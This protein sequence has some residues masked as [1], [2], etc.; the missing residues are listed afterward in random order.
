M[1]VVAFSSETVAFAE[2]FMFLLQLSNIA[3]AGQRGRHNR[4]VKSAAH[5]SQN[6]ASHKPTHKTMKAL[7]CK[8]LG[9]IH[10]QSTAMSVVYILR[11]RVRVP[12]E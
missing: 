11:M 6:C 2:S 9:G 1:E 4:L 5:A 10:M 12:P 8:T 3:I 7:K